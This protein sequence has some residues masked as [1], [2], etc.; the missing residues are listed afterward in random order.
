VQPTLL[1]LGDFTKT[2]PIDP[3]AIVLEWAMPKNIASLKMG[4]LADPFLPAKCVV[5]FFGRGWHC[6]V[7]IPRHASGGYQRRLVHPS[8]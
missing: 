8:G 2:P 1:P 6:Q 7:L 4:Y 5:G 3:A